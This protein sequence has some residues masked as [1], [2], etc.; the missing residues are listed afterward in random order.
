MPL[1]SPV[2]IFGA[3]VRNIDS[4]VD[5]L[6]FFLVIPQC[7]GCNGRDAVALELCASCIEDNFGKGSATSSVVPLP[8]ASTSKKNFFS[9]ILRGVA[10]SPNE[11]IEPIRTVEVDEEIAKSL[12]PHQKDAVEF[13]WRNSFT[14]YNYFENGDQSIIG[15]CLLA[16]HMGLGTCRLQ[17][18]V[19]SLRVVLTRD[20]C[21]NYS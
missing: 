6:L 15:G 16:H 2:L 8:S 14:D 1:V 5:V 4:F 12:K 10:P 18:F 20:S 3:E 9:W 17:G 19:L 7:K 21:L 11:N 13:I